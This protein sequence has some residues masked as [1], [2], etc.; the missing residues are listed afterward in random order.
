MIR[1]IDSVD[2]R[3][4][5]LT[6]HVFKPPLVLGVLRS[7]QEGQSWVH[8]AHID[9]SLRCGVWVIG[10]KE[11]RVNEIKRVSWRGGKTS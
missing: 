5:P 11:K 6:E 3:T 10:I 2:S 9:N 8:F 4:L 1:F 7:D